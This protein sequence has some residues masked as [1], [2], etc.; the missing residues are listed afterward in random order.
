MSN[1]SLIQSIYIKMI[2][3]NQLI[4]DDSIKF[5]EE[6]MELIKKIEERKD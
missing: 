4:E 5:T 1:E 2:N 3:V 6:E